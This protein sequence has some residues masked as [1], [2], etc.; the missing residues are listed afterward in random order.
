[1]QFQLT[2]LQIIANIQL[3]ISG[4]CQD[5]AKL[6]GFVVLLPDAVCVLQGCL[7]L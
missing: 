7:C 4:L 6:R 2:N 3:S 1:M 5:P